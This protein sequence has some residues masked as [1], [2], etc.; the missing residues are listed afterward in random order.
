MVLFTEGDALV[1]MSF[2]EDDLL[3]CPDNDGRLVDI[4][5]CLDGTTTT[6][7]N[8]PQGQVIGNG[9]P[10]GGGGGGQVGNNSSVPPN[11]Q[12]ATS[13]LA[14]NLNNNNNN[15]TSN[16]NHNNISSSSSSSSCNASSTT[17]VATACDL[18]NLD[19]LEG[20]PEEIL[21]Q[22]AENPFEIEYFFSD[23]PGVEVKEEIDMVGYD[24]STAFITSSFTPS[25]PG[26]PPSAMNGALDNGGVS[27][28]T[29]QSQ[30]RY[31]ISANSLLAEKLMG[32]QLTTTT[33]AGDAEALLAMGQQRPAGKPPD[34]IKGRRRRFVV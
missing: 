10:G 24:D 9:L 28:T 4:A 27:T 2:I 11:P 34:Q 25:S 33:T 19:S 21:R 3:W 14:A 6:N 18:A 26:L 29:G 20:E 1:P 23:M 13:I 5:S 32:A 12:T 30:N 16:H 31:S 22:L 15:N 8:E 7:G 17:V